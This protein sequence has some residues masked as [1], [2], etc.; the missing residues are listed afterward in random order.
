M[1]KVNNSVELRCEMMTANTLIPKISRMRNEFCINK[2]Q[3]NLTMKPD[4]NIRYGAF[5]SHD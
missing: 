4:E 1:L 3:C 5:K 2:G